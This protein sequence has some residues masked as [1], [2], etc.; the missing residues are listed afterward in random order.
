MEERVMHDGPDVESFCLNCG[1]DLRV[2][3]MMACCASPMSSA[4]PAPLPVEVVGGG[5]HPIGSAP[6][7][8]ASMHGW[9]ADLDID[10]WH[11]VHQKR[12]PDCF[13]REEHK[14]WFSRSGGRAYCVGTDA[15]FSHWM[16]P[17]GPHEEG[18]ETGMKEVIDQSA[19][20]AR[21]NELMEKAVQVWKSDEIARAFLLRPHPLLQMRTPIS[22]AM[23]NQVGTDLVRDI[24]L[25][26][27]HGTSI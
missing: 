26:L 14:A 1:A 22:V 19:K 23:T 4:L 2:I 3:R 10:L 24:L 18:L 25:R 20:L 17:R 15:D 16:R 6:K 8:P 12:Y 27:E 13:W 7:T 5:W 11:I 21:L 9:R